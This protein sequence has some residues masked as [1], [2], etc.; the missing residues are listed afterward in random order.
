[1]K[2]KTL[3]FLITALPFC[4]LAFADITSVSTVSDMIKLED[5]EDN[6]VAIVSGYHKTADGGG[7]MFRWEADRIRG[8]DN[9]LIFKSAFAQQGRWVRMFDEN[10]PVN[11][12]WFGAVGDGKIDDHRVIQKAIYTGRETNRGVYFPKGDYR[13]TK[14]LDFTRWGGIRVVGQDPGNTGI[15]GHYGVTRLLFDGVTTVGADFS[16]SCYG[17]VNGIAFAVMDK[18]RPEAIV[19]LARSDDAGYGS[20]ITFTN[21]NFAAGKIASIYCHSA[22]VI[23]LIDCRV[24]CGGGAPGFLITGMRDYGFSGSPF[25]KLCKG[26]SLTQWTIIGGEF[27]SGGSPCI[28][29]DG[30]NYTLAD[31]SVHGTYFSV[32]GENGC[33]VKFRGRC[34]NVVFSGHRC[35]VPRPLEENLGFCQ[36]DEAEVHG[37]QITG[38]I[39]KGPIVYGKG[40]MKGSRI[41]SSTYVELEGD[42]TGNDWTIYEPSEANGAKLP[43]STIAGSIEGTRINIYD[44]S[45][46]KEKIQALNK[47]VKIK[48]HWENKTTW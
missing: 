4:E 12:R 18:V 3:I 38:K 31:A 2:F 42:F 26:I 11:V 29:F 32:E 16:G 8:E 34:S 15:S 10:S 28:V 23:S 20:D 21:C 36:L 39:S 30:R 9:G 1:M 33:V 40:H 41:F 48:R 44:E 6:D 47:K 19:L 27:T 13:V 25:S 45:L 22:E 14:P 37:I 5:M 7:G 46:K 24:N 35:E 43:K 17:T